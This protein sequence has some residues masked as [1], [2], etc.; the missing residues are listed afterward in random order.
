MRTAATVLV[1]V[2]LLPGPALAA[3]RAGLPFVHDDYPKALALA[4][5]RQVPILAD[6]WA[7][8]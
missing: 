7:P 4:R 8:W 1:A 6:V 5:A 2:T 3:A